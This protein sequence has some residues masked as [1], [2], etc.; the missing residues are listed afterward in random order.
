MGNVN[1]VESLDE[2]IR[3]FNIDQAKALVW[4]A[5]HNKPLNS[6]GLLDIDVT[7]NELLENKIVFAK[8]KDHFMVEMINS[9]IKHN[10]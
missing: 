7:I 1:L 6:K 4:D 10:Y 3:I 2:E 5:I 8:A 9:K